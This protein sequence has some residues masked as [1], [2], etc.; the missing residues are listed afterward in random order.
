MLDPGNQSFEGSED[1][2]SAARFL[3]RHLVAMGVKDTAVW[4]DLSQSH[5]PGK[6]WHRAWV[7]VDQGVVHWGQ[8]LAGLRTAD[9]RGTLVFM[10]FYDSD[11]PDRMRVGLKREVAYLRALAEALD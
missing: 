5:A 1:W 10:P 9:F 11:C 3:D 6:G 7:P 8:V 2:V 4:R